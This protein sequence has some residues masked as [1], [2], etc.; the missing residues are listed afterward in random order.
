M[1]GIT[2]LT[3]MGQLGVAQVQAEVKTEA[4]AAQG[5]QGRQ[6][7]QRWPTK[8]FAP[9]SGKSR[10]PEE[11]EPAKETWS[12]VS[13]GTEAEVEE[14]RFAQVQVELKEEVLGDVDAISLLAGLLLPET[15]GSTL[16]HTLGSTLL[17]AAVGSAAGGSAAA[18]SVGAASRPRRTPAKR[19][20]TGQPVPNAA[21][22]RV[23]ER[24]RALRDERM[25]T[26]DYDELVHRCISHQTYRFFCHFST[27]HS[28]CCRILAER[29][30][31]CV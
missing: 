9:M 16:G 24:R 30:G 6:P 19:K 18:A 28:R 14:E 21:K 5:E 23:A 8:P 26:I 2:A 20:A 31:R 11:E 25:A 10:E 4:A 29:S 1:D 22:R 7:R 17:A 27:K 15:L 12:P 3:A 13:A